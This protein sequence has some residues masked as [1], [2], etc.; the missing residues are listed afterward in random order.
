MN[1]EQTLIDTGNYFKDKIIKGEFEFKKCEDHTA[2]V[3]IDNKYVF[4]LWIAN[5][6]KH[7]FRFYRYCVFT[8]INVKYLTFKTQKER[9]AG[10]RH[11]KPYVQKYKNEVLKK[12]K[13]EQF[14]KLK[15]ELEKLK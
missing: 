15:K 4:E 7:S 8:P 11:I 2:T 6:P 13:Q 10:W 1:I 9:L 5:E 12:E 14:N 3:L